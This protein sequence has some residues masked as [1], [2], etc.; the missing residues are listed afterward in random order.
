MYDHVNGIGKP[1]KPRPT[2]YN[3]ARGIDRGKTES[4]AEGKPDD[5]YFRLINTTFQNQSGPG[6]GKQRQRPTYDEIFW[7]YRSWC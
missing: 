6:D 7:Y 5:S 3:C 2:M 4:A 1:Q